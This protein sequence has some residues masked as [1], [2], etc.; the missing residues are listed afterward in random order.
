[1]QRARRGKGDISSPFQGEFGRRAPHLEF[2]VELLH[3][4]RAF[5]R[6]VCKRL[7]II[8]HEDTDTASQPHV[9]PF[10]ATAVAQ[11]M[12]WYDPD[13]LGASRMAIGNA[14]R[15]MA[16]AAK[17]REGDHFGIAVGLRSQ[18]EGF[19]PQI[20]DW[21]LD[22]HTLAGKRMGRRLDYFRE[23]S[24]QLVPPVAKDAYED[25]AYRMLALKA[26]RGERTSKPKDDDAAQLPLGAPRSR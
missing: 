6:M 17:S 3:T 9:V 26:T 11:A 14:I 23:H 19:V 16:R 22:G 8:S 21:A 20:P 5:H 7:E 24:A 2:A 15:M 13:K 1:M 12:R 4:S 25:E 10:V 18:L